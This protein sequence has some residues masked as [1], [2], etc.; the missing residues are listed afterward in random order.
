MYLNFRI[1]TI[2]RNILSPCHFNVHNVNNSQNANIIYTSFRS[3]IFGLEVTSYSSAH[4]S[5]SQTCNPIFRKVTKSAR[6]WGPSTI[7]ENYITY[8]LLIKF[9]YATNKKWEAKDALN[10]LRYLFYYSILIILSS[11][12]KSE[13]Y[14]IVQIKK[15]VKY[16]CNLSFQWALIQYM[17]KKLEMTFQRVWRNWI[18]MNEFEQWKTRQ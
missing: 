12:E 7:E 9:S 1:L 15:N 6:E 14:R 13:N 10:C 8:R 17:N 2:S 16:N 5:C 18:W 4:L 3:V 11:Q